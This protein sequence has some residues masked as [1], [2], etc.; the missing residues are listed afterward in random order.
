MQRFTLSISSAWSAGVLLAAL[1][2]AEPVAAQ[3]VDKGA[4]AGKGADSVNVI[5]QPVT[6]WLERANREYQDN[7]VRELSVPTGKGTPL[8]ASKA[9]PAPANQ[10]GL[11]DQV[12][13][14][15]GMEPGNIPQSDPAALAEAAKRDEALK[16]QV[17]ARKL[18]Q[19]RNAENERVAEQQRL[20][21]EAKK[22]AEVA[23]VT[24]QNQKAAES[25]RLAEEERRKSGGKAVAGSKT[26]EVEPTK[27]DEKA[28]ADRKVAAATA[29][30]K[31]ANE[32]KAVAAGEK[33][34]AEKADTER[35]AVAAAERAASERKAVA[36]S[37][38]ADA[39]RKAVAAAERAASERKAADKAAADRKA[40][41]AASEAKRQSEEAAPKDQKQRDQAAADAARKMA[42]GPAAKETTSPS[43]Q[44][45]PSPTKKAE[46]AA[47]AT[48]LGEKAARRAKAA[49][50]VAVTEKRHGKGGKCSRA[51]QEVEVPAIYVVKSGDTLWDISRRYYDKGI[52]FEKIVR[53]NHD[54]IES[55]SRIYPCQKFFLPGR[56]ALYWVLPLDDL[57]AS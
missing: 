9:V 50:R 46:R 52:R 4:K 32:R 38:K 10:P 56:S 54:K 24:K 19:E 15:L 39:E 27:A 41:A 11:M 45:D 13:G 14:L 36:A 42:Q 17:E 21:V 16:R 1:L 3:S 48:G 22:A 23:D 44:K 53:A 35:K 7:V 18:E 5:V 31:A 43:A 28:A 6:D 40:V 8:E 47:N 49:L 33:A 34:A 12:K 37:E 26:I 55:P 57:D 2:L 29:A 30:E 20:A 25:A 51:G